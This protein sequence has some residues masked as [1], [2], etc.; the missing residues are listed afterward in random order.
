MVSL[1][2]KPDSKILNDLLSV[3]DQYNIK[4]D[5]LI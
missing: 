5:I 3:L 4:S 2:E 1:W